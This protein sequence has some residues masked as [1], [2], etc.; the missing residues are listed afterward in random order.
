VPHEHDRLRQVDKGAVAF[1]KVAKK[2]GQRVCSGI[3]VHREKMDD[4]LLRN[5]FAAKIRLKSY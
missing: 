2:V 4:D 3:P 1:R 5:Y